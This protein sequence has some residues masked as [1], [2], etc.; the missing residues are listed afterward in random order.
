MSLYSLFLF[1]SYNNTSEVTESSVP[2]VSVSTEGDYKKTRIEYA[3]DLKFYAS[4]GML[5]IRV[6]AGKREGEKHHP[7]SP[8]N[9]ISFRI[10]K[11]D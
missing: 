9:G 6:E 3:L 10:T 2:S 4:A 1:R 11:R 7:D 5:Q 8:S